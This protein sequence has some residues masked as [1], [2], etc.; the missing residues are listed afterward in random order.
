VFNP[1]KAKSALAGI[2]APG[3]HGKSAGEPGVLISERI[4][5]GLATVAA[6]KGKADALKQA[7]AAAYG[8][9]LQGSSR[10]AQGS[11]V[12]FIGYGPGQWLAVSEGLANEALA[13]D[14]SAKLAGLASI[15]DQSGGRT[16]LRISGARARDVLAK[17]LPID[18][19][20]RVFPLGSAATSV[21]SHMGVQLWQLDDTRSYDIAIFRS[22]SESFWSWLA[23]SAAE[24]GYEVV[25]ERA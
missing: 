23:A 11:A 3:R 2:A 18:L 17:G 1:L 5:L 14:L 16:V 12:S 20:P 6:R 8:V 10:I 13:R 19:D 21:I 7:V 9:D 24:Y 25:P 22:L 15:S 4:G